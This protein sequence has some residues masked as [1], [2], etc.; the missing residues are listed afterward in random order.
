MP[1][2]CDTALDGRHYAEFLRTARCIRAESG[3]RVLGDRQ[4]LA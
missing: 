1:P 3:V 4:V 2:A